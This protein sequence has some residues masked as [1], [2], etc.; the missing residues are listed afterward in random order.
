MHLIHSGI[1]GT[2]VPCIRCGRV[3]DRDWVEWSPEVGRYVHA[4]CVELSAISVELP[5]ISGRMRDGR[6]SDISNDAADERPLEYSSAQDSTYIDSAGAHTLSASDH[7]CFFMNLI[8][9]DPIY[10][11]LDMDIPT[12]L[13]LR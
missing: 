2:A 11:A 4:T 12:I 6:S 3:I 13:R 1:M 5:A 10:V 9:L 8:G 7:Q